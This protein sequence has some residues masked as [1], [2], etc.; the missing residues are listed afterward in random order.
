MTSVKYKSTRGGEQGKTFE[1]VV[2]AGLA[3]DKGLYVPENIPSFSAAQLEQVCFTLFSTPN[4]SVA[5][6]F[7]I[8][9]YCLDAKNELS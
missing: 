3:K 5:Y 9:I 7:G 8:R 4:S 1:E 2:L 6:L